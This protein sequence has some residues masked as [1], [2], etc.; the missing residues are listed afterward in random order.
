MDADLRA[1]LVEQGYAGPVR[2]LEE[3]RCR[4]IV[5]RLRDGEREPADWHKGC[6]VSSWAFYDVA[7][8]PGIVERVAAVLGDDVMLWG[9]SLQTRAPDAVHPWHTD[10]EIQTA[11]GKSVSVWIGL[12]HTAA[13]S[14]LLL[15]PRSH[16]FGV[17]VQETAS[18]FGKRRR[19]IRNEDILGWAA[20]HE[21]Q[22]R[23]VQ[24]EM[25][26][27]EALFFDGALWHGSH[28][29]TRS[30]R[31]A[32]LLQYAVPEFPIRIPDFSHLEWPVRLLDTPRPQCIMVSGAARGDAN[33][34]VAA[35]ARPTA[36][37]AR[38][39]SN[40]VY[41]LR[42]P[43]AP[44]DEKGWKAYP[45]FRG[46]TAALR[47]LTCHASVL[48]HEQCPH[49]PHRHDEDEILIV[50]SGEV[51]IEVP[52]VNG[53][54]PNNRLR[55]SAGHFAYY[56]AQFAHTLRTVSIEPANYLMLKWQ[57]GRGAQAPLAFGRF[58]ALARVAPPSSD[59]GFR[60]QLLFEGPTASLKKLHSHASMLS[61]G[62]GYE[63]HVDAHDVAIVV[64]EGEVETLGERVKPFGVIFHPA[65]E[66]HGMT[67]PGP[68]P[69]RYVVFEFHGD[70]ARATETK[71]PTVPTRS[72]VD[73]GR[74][75]RAVKRLLVGSGHR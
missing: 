48:T 36:P 73:P 24:V 1:Q 7:R 75:G 31:R 22:S 4:Q 30:T 71:A 70:V 6:A 13:A 2:V 29:L 26:D 45:I 11:R 40:R 32:L 51:D 61:P 49:P 47:A 43:L 55:L 3:Q 59:K 34:I 25:S 52:D 64:L 62:A 19:E 72:L 35:P 37:D 54:A 27:G 23:I 50:L 57:G 18:R 65:G 21:S 58:D 15:M 16:R 8:N 39:L 60:A 56:P 38:K 53:D 63:A 74:W 12:E 42:I 17:T 41:P 46:S 28:N 66:S 67:N 20:M 5:D 10:I 33:R 9:A 14:S 69:A 44:D 68:T